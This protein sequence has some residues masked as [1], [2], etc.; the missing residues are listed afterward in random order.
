MI[1]QNRKSESK[2]QSNILKYNKFLDI[3]EFFYIRI[4]MNS[5]KNTSEN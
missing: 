5:S 2:E 1:H 4:I 3:I